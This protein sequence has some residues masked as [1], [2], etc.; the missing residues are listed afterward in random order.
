MNPP[1]QEELF[2]IKKMILTKPTYVAEV[3]F[4]VS[5]Y[6]EAVK[7]WSEYKKKRT[8]KIDNLHILNALKF[9]F[10]CEDHV[11][12]YHTYRDNNCLLLCKIKNK[13]INLIIPFVNEGRELDNSF[14]A[15]YVE[16][17]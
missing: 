9:H 6:G 13:F 2:F 12:M 10:D 11:L 3:P 4:R 14:I 16:V 17:H 7:L 15:T 5:N 8:I 1:T